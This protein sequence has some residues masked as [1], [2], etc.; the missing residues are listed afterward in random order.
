M[1]KDK[2]ELSLVEKEKLDIS[3]LSIMQDS[4][5]NKLLPNS[6]GCGITL[7]ININLK[8]IEKI[9]SDHYELFKDLEECFIEK[10]SNGL[11]IKYQ[12]SLDASN[13]LIFDK[14]P[15][16]EEL[17]IVP[18]NY[19]GVSSHKYLRASDEY[20]VEVLKWNQKKLLHPSELT[21]IPLEVVR[22]EMKK[23]G[24]LE[25]IDITHLLDVIIK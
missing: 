23:G 14:D 7:E 22:K 13:K 4:L 12:C 17:I 21:V 9:I 15:E 20:K 18:E 8:K 25:G 24:K 1:R 11:K 5:R 3:E 6:K 19:D 2:E 10:D 16:T